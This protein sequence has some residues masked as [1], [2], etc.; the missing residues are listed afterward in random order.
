MSCLQQENAINSFLGQGQTAQ[1]L[2]NLCYHLRNKSENDWEKVK[3]YIKKFFNVE[4]SDPIYDP[5][6]NSAGTIELDYSQINTKDRLDIALAGA[7]SN[8]YY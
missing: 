7:D 5:D 2:R 3:E 1:V 6:P 8:K 4:L